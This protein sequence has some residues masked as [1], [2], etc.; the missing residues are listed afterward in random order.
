MIAHDF[1]PSAAHKKQL[2]VKARYDA[3]AES[4]GTGAVRKAIEK[5]QKKIDQKEKK[6][7]PF[8][9][10][11]EGKGTD[12]GGGKRVAAGGGDRRPSKRPRHS[13]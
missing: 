11:L 9:A 7:R 6:K 13:A 2:L 12:G 8:T 1:P 4:G 5:K 10:P 3:L